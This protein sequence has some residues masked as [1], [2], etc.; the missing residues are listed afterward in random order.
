MTLAIASNGHSSEASHYRKWGVGTS[1][2]Y[3]HSDHQ[4]RMGTEKKCLL[5]PER[6]ASK[7]ERLISMDVGPGIELEARDQV[8]GP[9]LP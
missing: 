8:E 4:Y 5:Y 6:G 9:A 2:I 1:I 3:S 7:P